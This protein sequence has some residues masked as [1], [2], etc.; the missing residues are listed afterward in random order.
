MSTTIILFLLLIL[1]FALSAFFS[2]SETALMSIDRYKLRHHAR[3]DKGARLVVNLLQQPDRLIGLI[4]LGN[5]L[6]NILITQIASYLGYHLA[7]S[8]GVAIATGVLALL[9]LIF[10]ELAPK[11]LAT[12]KADQF[13]Y[14]AARIYTPLLKVAGPLVWLANQVANALI[15]R[16]GVDPQAVQSA[17]INQDELRTLVR[18][19]ESLIPNNHQQ[20]LLSVLDLESITVEDIMIPRMD[21]SGIDLAA[22]WS[23]IERQIARSPF[24]RML[25]YREKLENTLGFL[26]LRQL[27]PFIQDNTLKPEVIEESM[28]DIF[29]TLETTVLTQ[30]LINFQ[31]ERTRIALVVDEY[32]E[33]QGLV[34][35]E[36]I[37]EEIVGQFVTDPASITNDLEIKDDG[38]TWVDGGMPVRE[39]N[40]LAGLKL[41]M[42]QD[43]KTLNGLVIEY[44]ETI[45]RKG[46]C[47]LIGGYPI[48]VRRVTNNTVKTLIISP[49][50]Q[51]KQ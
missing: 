28:T 46:L 26:H 14:S 8:S 47:M 9:L 23:L 38:T 25:V 4:L 18:E 35:I 44:L 19:S 30:Q 3:R 10:A 40:R 45:P 29:F 22:D 42:P 50:L 49:K 37:L 34:T 5:N 16:F 2:G 39:V 51:G 27:L 13:A 32:G 33:I 24:S 20:M 41:P 43:A 31:S 15:R 36:D 7:G 12:V 6:V 21:I 1:L 11:T 17:S 48:E